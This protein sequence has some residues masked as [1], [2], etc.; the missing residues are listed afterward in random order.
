LL[1]APNLLIYALRLLGGLL[2]RLGGLA[3][4]PRGHSGAAERRGTPDN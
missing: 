4:R 2:L 3:G 1:I